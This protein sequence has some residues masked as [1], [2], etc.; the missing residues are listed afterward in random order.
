MINANEATR[1]ESLFTRT[2]FSQDA[3]A[4][5]I[6]RTI[7]QTPTTSFAALFNATYKRTGNW[8]SRYTTFY[9]NRFGSS[10]ATALAAAK[11]VFF[12][13]GTV[14][15]GVRNDL[16]ANDFDSSILTSSDKNA[17]AQAYADAIVAVAS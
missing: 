7:Y 1:P 11:D 5:N 13:T 15:S 2:D 16:F 6:G 4:Y 10:P 17:V 3:V 9:A 12:D 8:A 14:I